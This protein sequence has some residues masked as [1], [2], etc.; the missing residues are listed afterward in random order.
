MPQFDW[1]TTDE[2]IDQVERDLEK[3]IDKLH[4]ACSRIL[5]IETILEIEKTSKTSSRVLDA[6]KKSSDVTVEVTE[7]VGT[8]Q[9]YKGK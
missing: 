3:V 5:V 8:C 1:K 7:E 2:H 6:L 9:P 4:E